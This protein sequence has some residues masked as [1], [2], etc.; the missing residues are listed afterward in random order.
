MAEWVPLVALFAGIAAVVATVAVI[1]RR[2][3]QRR[4]EALR[5]TASMLGFTLEAESQKP[6]DAGFDPALAS[7]R[8]GRSSKIRNLMRGREIDG[9]LAVFDFR[10]TVSTGKSAHTVEQTVAGF[11]RKTF[12]LPP[13]RLR[14]ENL[15][16]RIGQ[17]FGQQDIDID[18]NP[19]FSKAYRLSG[20]EPDQVRSLFERQAAHY[21]GSVP[22]W[23]VEGLGEWLLV[24]RQGVRVKPEQYPTFLEETRRIA[25]LF[26]QR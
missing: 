24:F 8:R 14:P 22:G 21:L 16:D 10:Y 11:R 18:S 19:E 23:T 12:R 3:E 15:F 2:G 6:E 25:R 26:E 13:F 7:L 17:V 4:S 1:V 5:S 9:D 20:A